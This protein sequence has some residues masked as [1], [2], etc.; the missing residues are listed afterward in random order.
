MVSLVMDWIEEN[1]GVSG[2]EAMR[3]EKS[4]ILY[5]CLDESAMFI[6]HAEPEHRSCMNV[7]FRTASPSWTLRLSS[8]RRQTALWASRGTAPWAACAPRSTMPCPWRA[9]GSWRLLSKI[10]RW[11][12]VYKVKILNHL[13]EA[14][15]DVLREAGFAV[16][17]DIESPE[18]ILVRSADMHGMT[19]GKGLLCIAR[20]GAGVNNI[21]V[22]GCTESGI[23]V[24]NTPGANA[25]AVKELAICSILIA[26][27]DVLGGVEWVRGAAGDGGEIAALVEKNKANFVGPEVMGKTLGV[28]GLGAVAPRSP[29]WR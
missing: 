21:P 6:G 13:A 18:A 26:S 15:L 25:E 5:D 8:R 29:T 27:R 14:G 24:F 11:K 10:S 17:E 19:F 7:T 1:G 20:A 9:S 23:V 3:G 16:S 28:V 4:K 22:P 2:M 12:T